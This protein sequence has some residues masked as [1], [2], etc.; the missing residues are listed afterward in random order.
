MSIFDEKNVSKS[1]STF[2]YRILIIGSVVIMVSGLIIYYVVSPKNGQPI[3]EPEGL[4]L[5]VKEHLNKK[6]PG[7]TIDNMAFYNC[8]SVKMGKEMFSSP[9]YSIIVKMKRLPLDLNIKYSHDFDLQFQLVAKVPTSELK[10]WEV[11][12]LRDPREHPIPCEF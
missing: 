9:S 11:V 6:L 4:G 2:N 3:T 12:G 10:N 7:R 5:A 8:N 1:N